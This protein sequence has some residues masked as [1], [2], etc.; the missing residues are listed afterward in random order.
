MNITDKVAVVTGA[1]KIDEGGKPRIGNALAMELAQKG[2]RVLVHYSSSKEGAEQT[3][4]QIDG[5]GGKATLFQASLADNDV[6][7]KIIREAEKY[8]GKP[9]QILVNSAATFPTDD[10]LTTTETSMLETFKIISVGP[11]LLMQAMARALPETEEGVVINI[12]DARIGRRPYPD[13]YSYALA[14]AAFSEGSTSAALSLAPR[15]R[16]VRVSPGAILQAAG[17]SAAHHE[18]VV[19]AVPLGREGGVGAIVKAVLDA[20]DNDFITGSNVVVD[21]GASLE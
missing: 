14:K 9:V 8:F 7:E 20:I 3:V 18:K 5:F 19:S 6:G 17:K 10:I 21:G 2:A 16:V 15:I 4:K 13:H 12:I 1:G 11:S